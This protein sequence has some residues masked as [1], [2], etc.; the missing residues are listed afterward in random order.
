MSAYDSSEEMKM[1]DFKQCFDVLMRI[2]ENAR[3]TIYTF[4]LIYGALLLWTANAVIYPGEQHRLGR[5]LQA[6]AEVIK[7]LALQSYGELN[8]KIK[9]QCDEI[10]KDR[11]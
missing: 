4:I 6:N 5:V 8:P 9:T 2:S 7:C 11:S 3:T 10:L 1:E